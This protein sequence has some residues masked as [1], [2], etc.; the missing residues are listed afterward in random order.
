MR[1][2]VCERDCQVGEVV[3]VERMSSNACVDFCSG[4]GR[5]CN[6]A[7]I[8]H[9][10]N[11]QYNVQY[12]DMEE[13]REIMQAMYDGQLKSHLQ[14]RQNN[15]NHHQHRQQMSGMMNNGDDQLRELTQLT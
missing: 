8:S 7:V 13:S 10:E 6:T 11:G 14:R 2:Y 15:N 9:C 4:R 3:D 5:H 1:F 12:Y